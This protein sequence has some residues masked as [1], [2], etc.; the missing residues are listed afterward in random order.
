MAL[1]NPEHKSKYTGV[2]GTARLLVGHVAKKIR[3][4]VTGNTG[5]S[6]RAAHTLKNRDNELQRKMD[7]IDRQHR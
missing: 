7:E 1:H 2:A 3:G 4:A 5:L 6:G